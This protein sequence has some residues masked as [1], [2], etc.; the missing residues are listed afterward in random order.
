MKKYHAT[1]MVIEDDPNDQFLIVQAFK[2][3][4][5]TDPIQVVADGAEAIAYM[6]GEGK[7]ADRQKYAYPTFIITDLKMPKCDGF[8]VLEFLKNNPEWKVIPTIVLS[9]SSDPDDIKKSYMLGASSYHVKP[10]SHEELLNQLAVI[11]AY[12]M[13]CQVPEVDI[14][15]KQLVTNSAGKLGERFPQADDPSSHHPEK[16]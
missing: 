6:M 16:T 2:K 8:A 15:G 11:N 7:Y 12:W 14:T 3:I 5:V 13:T 10:R 9:A 1:I 4:G